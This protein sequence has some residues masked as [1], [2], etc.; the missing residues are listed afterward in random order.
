MGG[1]LFDVRNRRGAD[2]DSDHELITGDIKIKLTCRKKDNTM[3][4]HKRL[5][6]QLVHNPATKNVLTRTFR[7]NLLTNEQNNVW[8]V[9]NVTL[10]QI[11]ENKIGTV[12]ATKAKPWI[13]AATWDINQRT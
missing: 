1:S 6:V 2:I 4:R 11:A 7:E 5:N 12:K 8:E 3:H 10:R 13:S 9:T